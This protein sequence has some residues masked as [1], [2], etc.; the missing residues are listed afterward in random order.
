[1]PNPELCKA[2]PVTCDVPMQG[3]W[4]P[5][6][7]GTGYQ[8]VKALANV[9]QAAVQAGIDVGANFVPWFFTFTCR[10]VWVYPDNA[11]TENKFTQDG[12]LLGAGRLLKPTDFIQLT[13]NGKGNLV[14]ER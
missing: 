4:S 13:Y 11:D 6:T 5:A 1:R 7:P 2:E 10:T 14:S 12:G 9:T 3:T 8:L